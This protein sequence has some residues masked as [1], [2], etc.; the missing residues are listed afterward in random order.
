[1]GTMDASGRPLSYLEPQKG[2][3]SASL[4]NFLAAAL[5]DQQDVRI[6]NPDFVSNTATEHLNIVQ[7]SD[8]WITF[9][10]EGAGNLNTIGFYTYPTTNPPATVNDI[11]EVKFIF[12]NASAVG[13]GGTME[14]GDKVHLGQ[15]PAGTS[16][17][18]RRCKHLAAIKILF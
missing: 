17:G 2:T 10:A 3:V 11:N 4:L 5:P 15:F 16:M 9:V 12:P 7:L 13:T 14:S 18:W 6:T 8:V 1:M